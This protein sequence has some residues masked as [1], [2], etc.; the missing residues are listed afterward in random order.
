MNKERLVAFTDAIAAIAATIM[1]LEL[2]VPAT[3]DWAG[4]WAERN[5][6]LAYIV[7]YMMI[8]LVWYMH[9]NLFQKAAVISTKTFLINGIWLFFLTLVPF[10]TAWVGNAPG[11][12]APRFVYTLNM[13]LWALCFQWM[14]YQIRQ[15]NPDTERDVSNRFIDRAIMYGGFA[16]CLGLSFVFEQGV[17]PL[18]GLISVVMILRML[19]AARKRIRSKEA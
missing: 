12:S 18:I 4:L 1:V 10:T 11:A 17:V 6:I 16:V 7:S 14:D 8:Y 3:N 15:D 5:I 9:H 19:F 2:G 13:L